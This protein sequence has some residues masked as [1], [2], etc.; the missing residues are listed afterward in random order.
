[1]NIKPKDHRRMTLPQVKWL[2]G[3]V[4]LISCLFALA[5]MRA[6]T[7]PPPVSMPEWHANLLIAN[8]MCKICHNKEETG[9]QFG[10]WE[11]GPHA[12]AY[13]TLATARAREVAKVLGIDNPQ[14][15]GKCL[16]CHSTAY[17]FTQEPVTK[18]IPI[19]E[20]ISCQSC[21]GPAKNYMPKDKH[22][23]NRDIAIKNG[24]IYPT[25]ANTCRRCHNDSN[26]T[27]NPERYTT[28]DGRKVDFDYD[29]AYEKI[30][31]SLSRK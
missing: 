19:D 22:A 12:H 9:N 14:S 26:P 10:L 2:L 1:M 31:H 4:S 24:M 18:A 25:E 23:R 29:A 11:K 13:A 6:E 28:R 27:Y 15:S 7:E 3:A 5:V 17:G 21:H 20:G 16:Q 8:K 30:K